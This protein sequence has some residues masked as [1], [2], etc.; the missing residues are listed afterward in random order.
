MPGQSASECIALRQRDPPIFFTPQQ[1]HRATDAGELIF[2]R[3]GITLIHLHDLSVKSGLANLAHPGRDISLQYLGRQRLES[4]ALKIGTHDR[5]VDVCRRI[6]EG[7]FVLTHM[8][9]QR[10]TP[11]RQGNGIDQGEA[12]VVAAIQQMR[13]QCRGTAKIMGE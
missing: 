9:N 10:R 1:Q 7:P 3:I 8:L 2:Y 13:A 6:A 11:G 4:G 5:L 12:G